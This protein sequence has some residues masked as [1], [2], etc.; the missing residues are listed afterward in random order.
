VISKARN[1]LPLLGFVLPTLVIGYGF[2]IP[3]SC[4]RGIN[5]LSIGFGTTVLGAALTYVAGVRSASRSS[6]PT[7]ARWRRRLERYVNRQAAHPHG[8]F[9][10]LLALVWTFEHRK[11]NRT[12]LD[13]LQ[14][15]PTDRVAE[16]GCGPG[17][18]VHEAATRATEGHVIG[19]DVSETILSAARRANRRALTERRVSLRRID[20]VEL[21]LGLETLDRV[22]SVHSIYFW[23]D[24]EG[25]VAQVFD[26]LCP[27]GRLVLAFR[28]DDAGVPARFHDDT[29]RFFAPAEVERTLAAAG[30]DD[31]RTVRDPETSLGLVWVVAEKGERSGG[32]HEPL[33]FLPAS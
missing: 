21:G 33:G 15:R 28:P 24:L 1:Y 11:V 9:G 8:L 27:G 32:R 30:F 14:V 20:G 12:T 19:L 2:V 22:F 17:W 5:E 4:I 25:I 7:R 29:Y 10:R 16:V 13:L 23:K 3:R 18:A 6:C 31:V 26:A